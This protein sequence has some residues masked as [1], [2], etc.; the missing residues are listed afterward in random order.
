MS[1]NER[2][3]ILARYM[4]NHKT[5]VRQ[6]AKAFSLSKSTVH[7]D[8]SEK[9]QKVNVKLFYLVKD[10]LAENFALRHIRGGEATRLKYEKLKNNSN[11]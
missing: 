10:V 8:V 4:I 6:T 5:T 3:V 7:K 9:L 1:D 11:F 2:C